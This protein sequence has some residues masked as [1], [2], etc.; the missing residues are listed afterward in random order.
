[1][2]IQMCKIMNIQIFDTNIM[3]I[4]MQFQYYPARKKSRF[5]ICVKHI[6]MKICVYLLHSKDNT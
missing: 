4:H 6:I 3:Y 2:N 1:M 5:V